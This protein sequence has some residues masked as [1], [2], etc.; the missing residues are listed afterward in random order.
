MPKTSYV[1]V[2]RGVV[3]IR[4]GQDNPVRVRVL[5]IDTQGD[6]GIVTYRRLW[7][8]KR[9]HAIRAKFRER[10]VGQPF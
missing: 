4:D 9:Y 6:S 5:R 7:S 8:F 10:I 2:R 3:W 1:I